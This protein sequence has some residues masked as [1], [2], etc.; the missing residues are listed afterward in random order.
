MRLTLSSIITLAASILAACARYG[1]GHAGAPAVHCLR[2]NQWIREPIAAG[3]RF[4]SR[5]ARRRWGLSSFD[6]L[7][8]ALVN[9]NEL[10]GRIS[11][12]LGPVSLTADM[13]PR[14]HPEYADVVVVRLG[15]AGY[16]V[17]SEWHVSNAG[18]FLCS[19]ALLSAD[20]KDTRWLCD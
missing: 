15:K 11:K 16:L 10:C 14:A 19:R 4:A 3:Q 7:D 2:E 18:E 5:V 12:A 1:P 8:V 6:S 13:P 20:L 17:S 9:D